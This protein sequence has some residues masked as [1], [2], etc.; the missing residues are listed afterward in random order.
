VVVSGL[1]IRKKAPKAPVLGGGGV[2]YGTKRVVGEPLLAA[3]TPPVACAFDFLPVDLDPL[4]DG[5]KGSAE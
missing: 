2:P 4:L 3:P 1:C 5:V